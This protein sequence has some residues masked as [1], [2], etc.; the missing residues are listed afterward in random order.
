MQTDAIAMRSGPTLV[1]TTASCVHHVANPLPRARRD[2]IARFHSEIFQIDYSAGKQK[3]ALML[4]YA[5]SN[6]YKSTLCHGV[7]DSGAGQQ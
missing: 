6:A 1:D 5:V 2:R 3:F 7:L 4:T